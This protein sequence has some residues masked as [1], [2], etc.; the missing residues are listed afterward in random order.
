[1][2]I[3]YQVNLDNLKVIKNKSEQSDLFFSSGH[4]QFLISD[5]CAIKS[6]I[7]TSFLDFIERKNGI[8]IWDQDGGEITSYDVINVTTGLTKCTY[9]AYGISF[10]EDDEPKDYIVD[11]EGYVIKEDQYSSY[12]MTKSVNVREA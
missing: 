1:M 12:F 9:E 5:F 11:I 10:D 8:E 7:C 3:N 2:K 4:P 6:D